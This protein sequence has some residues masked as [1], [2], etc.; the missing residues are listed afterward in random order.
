MS[1]HEI[2]EE[3]CGNP[4]NVVS[5]TDEVWKWGTLKERFLYPF[6]IGKGTV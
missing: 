1:K 6:G 3:I 4:G 2:N 5:W